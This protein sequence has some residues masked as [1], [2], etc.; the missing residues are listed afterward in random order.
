V[1]EIIMRKDV[2][3]N[4]LLDAAIMVV[5][6]A[7]AVTG[8]EMWNATQRRMQRPEQQ[9]ELEHKRLPWLNVHRALS[10]AFVGG[11]VVHLLWHWRWIKANTPKVVHG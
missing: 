3:R 1:E 6:S 9:Q 10:L 5:T 11:T 8:G 7:L 2:Q 4:Y